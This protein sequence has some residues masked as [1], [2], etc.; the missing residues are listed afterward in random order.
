[1]AFTFFDTTKGD[2]VFDSAD[3]SALLAASPVALAATTISA[4]GAATFGDIA[5][6]LTAVGTNRATSLALTK[7][8]NNVTTA[9]TTA[10]GVTLPPAVVG[11]PIFVWNNGAAAMHV[12][13]DGS[14]TIDG[15][16]AAT[17]V[18]LTNGKGGIFFPIAA[19]TYLSLAA[20]LSA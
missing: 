17:G 4:S 20:V 19:A 18:V 16:A 8:F 9:A 10:V 5:T 7:Q 2:V 11:K 6:G 13:G 1:M 3:V 14:D 12:Y 15:V